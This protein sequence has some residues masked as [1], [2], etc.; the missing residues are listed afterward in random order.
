MLATSLAQA[1][2]MWKLRESVPE[3]QRRHGAS[4]KHDVSGPVSAIP[5]LIEKGNALALHLAPEGDVVSYGHAGDAN[6]HF[7]LS[8]KPGADVARFLGRAHA[9]ELPMLALVEG[10]GRSISADYAI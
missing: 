2:A 9:L 6:L 4:I 5:T 10:V 7:N 1:Q 8:H 3:A